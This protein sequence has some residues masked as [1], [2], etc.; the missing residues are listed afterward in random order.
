MKDLENRMVLDS[1]WRHR[2]RRRRYSDEW[3]MDDD[4][5]D[6]D[7]EWERSGAEAAGVL[8]GET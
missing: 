8:G 5:D 2:E 3:V 4:D 7:E 6:D 1:E